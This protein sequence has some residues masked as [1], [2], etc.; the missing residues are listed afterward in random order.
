M[1]KV[2]I[3]P[4]DFFLIATHMFKIDALQTRN[5]ERYLWPS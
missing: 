1:N 2:I 5:F 3:L 4:E